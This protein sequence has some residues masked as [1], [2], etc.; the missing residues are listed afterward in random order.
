ME[1]DDLF[2]ILLLIIYL[3]FI[4]LGL[5]D[6]VMGAAWPVMHREF[7]VQQFLGI[8]KKS[9]ITL[10]EF[11]SRIL[12]LLFMSVEAVD[13]TDQIRRVSPGKEF[14]VA[15]LPLGFI[16]DPNI[17]MDPVGMQY[18]RQLLTGH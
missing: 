16:V 4:S 13:H 15:D 3:S 1:G 6:A 12:L 7:A 5:P 11:P 9:F 18:L 17:L 14:P 10:V 2:S 8:M